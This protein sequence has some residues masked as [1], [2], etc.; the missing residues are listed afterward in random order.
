M[1]WQC[2][3]N[4]GVPQKD[5]GGL[6]HKTLG[7]LQVLPEKDRAIYRTFEVA[8]NATELYDPV[9]LTNIGRVLISL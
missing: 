7:R 8:K 3:A 2:A 6:T 9:Q 4:A 5:E 1:R